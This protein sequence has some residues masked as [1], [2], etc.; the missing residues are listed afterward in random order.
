MTKPVLDGEVL[1]PS[2]F[3]QADDLKGKDWT[4][5]IESVRKEELHMRGQ[6]KKLPK[7][8]LTFQR[9]RKKMVC[10]VTNAETIVDLYGKEA[11]AWIGKAITIYPTKVK[12]GRA[13]VDAIRVRGKKPTGAAASDASQ[14]DEHTAIDDLKKLLD[15]AKDDA[16][17]DELMTQFAS[18]SPEQ[19]DLEA[20]QDMVN[21]RKAKLAGIEF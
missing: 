10:N 16:Q 19:E 20:A 14:L 1:F 12:F 4:L 17:C 11:R 6:A 15:A 21:A 2:M 8:V 5:T 13:M 7:V 18:T 9:A 3:I